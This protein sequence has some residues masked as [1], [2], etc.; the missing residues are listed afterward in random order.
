VD[1]RTLNLAL[2]ISLTLHLLVLILLPDPTEA[3]AEQPIAL[4][5][6]WI[7][8]SVETLPADLEAVPLRQEAPPEVPEPLPEAEEPDSSTIEEIADLP[9][10]APLD[11]LPPQDETTPPTETEPTT[12]IDPLPEPDTGPEDR[13]TIAEEEESERVSPEDLERIEE[14]LRTTR[15]QVDARRGT[16]RYQMVEVRERVLRALQEI[17]PGTRVVARDAA[18]FRCLMSFS[19]DE[20]GYIFD[21]GLRFP[22]GSALDARTIEGA[23]IAL[24]P[25][26]PPPPEVSTPLSIEWQIDFLD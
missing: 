21:L 3:R 18:R 9:A 23:V 2:W 6:E 20:D 16:E 10:P 5:V 17:H 8:A 22:L 13:S 7:A 15:L 12:A 26:S 4:E 24:S 25:L 19:V 1:D 14:L 11:P